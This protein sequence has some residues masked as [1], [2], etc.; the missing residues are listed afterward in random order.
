[1]PFFMYQASYTAESWAA[2]MKNPENRVQMVGQQ[3]CEAVGGKLVTGWYC[4]GE[5]DIMVICNVPN[6][7]AMAAVAIALGAGGALKSGK[8]TVLMGG[9][10]AV[11]AIK[12]A[13]DVANVYHPADSRPPSPAK[14]GA[15]KAARR[16]R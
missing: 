9:A 15:A 7:Q 6:A 2:Q 13:S 16:S 3:A 12:Q 14:V 8:T 1:M 4:F 5:Y 10:Q 11:E